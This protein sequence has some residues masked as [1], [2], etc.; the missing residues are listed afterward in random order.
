MRPVTGS[1]RSGATA[2]SEAEPCPYFRRDFAL[3][4]PWQRP[5][6]SVTAL[7]VYQVE[8]NG[9]RVGDE[10]LAPGWTSYRHRLRFAS[11]DVTGL[12]RDGDNAIGAI[13]GD[14]WAVRQY[15]GVAHGHFSARPERDGATRLPEVVGF[16]AS[17]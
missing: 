8:I 13:V 2:A 3:D 12:L 10:E 7:G 15:L 14:G 4:Q 5:V 11:H 17:R 1:T 9:R 6:L 16:W